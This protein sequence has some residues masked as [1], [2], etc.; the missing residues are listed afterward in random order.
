MMIA[1]EK[2]N[3]VSVS[4]KVGSKLQVFYLKPR[5]TEHLVYF[6]RESLISMTHFEYF[7]V[8]F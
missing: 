7:L 1:G 5:P 8:E 2:E 4:S 6:L 3:P